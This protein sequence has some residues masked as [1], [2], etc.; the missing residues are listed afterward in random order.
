MQDA[1]RTL[2]SGGREQRRFAL[3]LAGGLTA[4]WS[5][6]GLGA[7][8]A[9]PAATSSG[10]AK[11]ETVVRI[12]PTAV[13]TADQITLA[14]VGEVHGEAAQ[15]SSG[16][17]IAAAPEVG[18]ERVITLEQV[19][20]A[21][22]RRGI[23]PATWVFRGSTTC[24]VSRPALSSPAAGSPSAEP[25]PRAGRHGRSSDLLEHTFVADRLASVTQPVIEVDPNTLE[26]AI[27][28][29]VA[30]RLADLGGTPSLS[31]SP[32]LSRILA[33]SRPTYDFRITDRSDRRLGLV[34]LEITIYEGGRVKQVVPALVQVSLTKP[35]VV[36][37]TAINRGQTVRAE[38]L[39]L[40]ERVFDRP[41][42]I[43]A[44]NP[45]IFV[46]QR[47]RRFLEKGDAV[48][49]RDLEVIPLVTR[50]DLVTVWSRRGQIRI[51][52]VAK[53]MGAASYGE[54]VELRSEMSKRTF[55]A[56]VTGPK[57]AELASGRG[58][59]SA[60]VQ[61]LAGGAR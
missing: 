37:A 29:H 32:S 35:V 53:A 51:K 39:T 21:L 19:Q 52:S 60:E 44:G 61:V 16:W 1:R 7:S 30:Q 55:L 36:A 18:T 43:G 38:H 5:L 8:M 14:D 50:N 59:A 9:A 34:P 22:R 27:R 41:E 25:D 31:F 2:R 45:E 54:T 24:R 42:D 58:T 28:R 26:G 11:S 23:N 20:T 48:G 57:T 17:S 12:L 47:A 33:L 4:A 49:Q 6:S 15:L 40:Q 46:G 56:V 13:V 3:I 10:P